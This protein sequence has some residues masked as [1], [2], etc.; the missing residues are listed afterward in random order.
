MD[1]RQLQYILTIAQEQNISHAAEKLYIT[2]SALNYSLLNLE[3]ELGLPLFKR[4]SNRLVPTYAGELY[5]EKARQILASCHELDHTMSV[6]TDSAH[7][8]LNLGITFGGGQELFVNV[9][10]ELHKKY[11]A[12]TVHLVEGN[13]KVLENALLSGEIDLAWACTLCDDPQIDHRFLRPV[14]TLKL[15]VPIGHP[16]LAQLEE[17]DSEKPLDIRLFHDDPFV[18]MNSNSFIRQ[19]ANLVFESAGFK[20]KII[21]ETSL[22]RMAVRFVHEGIAPTFIPANQSIDPDKC[23]IFTVAP[24]QEL[25]SAILFR[26]GTRFSEPENELIR[27]LLLAAN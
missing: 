21:M 15:A 5:L 4:L 12:I 14:T 18:L 3:K 24:Q 7:G 27:L 11:P 13:N 22:M 17:M 25:Y 2:R 8:R 6:L 20:P 9:F 16:R 1:S 10:P 26:K 23:R 19:K